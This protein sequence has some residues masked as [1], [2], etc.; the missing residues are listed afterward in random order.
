MTYAKK[1]RKLEAIY[2]R[3]PTLDC[4]GCCHSACTV[5][6]C[7]QLEDLRIMKETG[8]DIVCTIEDIILA[9]QGHMPCIFLDKNKR[10]E[11][12]PVRPAICRLF[13]VAEGL[14]C[15]HGCKPKKMLIRREA[16]EILT[17]IE[18]L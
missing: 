12:Y 9:T 5:I 15:P 18:R 10:C 3:I 1:I 13:G 4:K 17:E 2:A 6:G 16:H 7:S 8:K 14:E 11:I